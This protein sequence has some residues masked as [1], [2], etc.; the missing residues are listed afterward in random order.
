[1]KG[2]PSRSHLKSVG[3]KRFKKF[4]SEVRFVLVQD[5]GLEPIIASAVAG[6]GQKPEALKGL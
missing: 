6:F 3:D 2:T 4:I 5:N 1:M